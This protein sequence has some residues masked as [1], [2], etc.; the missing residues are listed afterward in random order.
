MP[1][2]FDQVTYSIKV[3]TITSRH[4]YSNPTIDNFASGFPFLLHY[5]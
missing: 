5:L 1:S 3:Y 2:E 4:S